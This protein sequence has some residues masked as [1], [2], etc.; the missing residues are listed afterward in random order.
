[1]RLARLAT[2]LP[3]AGELAAPDAGFVT[4]ARAV[5]DARESGADRCHHLHAPDAERSRR[6]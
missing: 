6:C 3:L 1:M 4:L 2:P 5:A